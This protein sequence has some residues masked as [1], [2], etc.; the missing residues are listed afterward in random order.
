MNINETLKECTLFSD[1][2]NDELSSLAKILEQKK[3]SKNTHLFFEGDPA[4]NLYILASGEVKLI[5]ASASGKEQLIRI[6]YPSEIFAEAAM[7]AGI[8]YPATSITTKDSIVFLLNKEKFLKLIKKHP[9]VSVR[10]MGTMSKL[11]IHLNKMVSELHLG[12]VQMRLA[13]YLLDL[14]KEKKSTKFELNIKKQELAFQLGTIKETLSRN[15]KSL[16]KQG[17]IEVNKSQISILRPEDLKRI[18]NN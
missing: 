14:S 13:K 10:M 1:L 16:Q 11:L 15:L 3:V 5:K 7:F 9:N 17:V 12:S 4:E 8:N 6:V 2:K 18:A